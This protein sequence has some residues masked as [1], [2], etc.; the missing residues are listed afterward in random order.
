MPVIDCYGQLGPQPYPTQATTPDALDQLMTKF[1]VDMTFVA[2]TEALR[3]SMSAGNA[4]LAEQIYER[5]RFRG[6]CVVNPL[7]LEASQEQM[8]KYLVRDYFVGA[9]LHE[10]YIKRPLNSEPMRA[11][12]KSLLRY[13]G[14]FLLRI[15]DPREIN[16]LQELAKEFPTQRFI[17]LHMGG[18]HW[19]MAL[20]LASKITNVYLETGGMVADYDKLAEAVELVGG[21]RLLFGSGMPLINP[22]YA[23][24][25]IRDSSISA[26][27]KERILA[28][29]ARKVFNLD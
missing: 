8:R 15:T 27:E 5:P 23:L 18:E 19:P 21:H 12:V 16:D 26:I 7:M 11:L 24:G 29:N 17:I 3:G 6:Y 1:G 10:G 13:D 20:A 9:M 22:V 4:W 14:P 28:R 25:M 2:A